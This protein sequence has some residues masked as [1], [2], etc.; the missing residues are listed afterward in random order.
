[1]TAPDPHERLDE[2]AAG[3]ALHALEP[4]D[5]QGFRV[6]LATCARCQ[7][8]VA[9]HTE[10]LSHLAYAA[11]PAEL[12]PSLLE[13]IRREVRGDAP[14]QPPEP[15]SLDRARHRR[16]PGLTAGRSWIAAAAAVALVLSLGVWNLALQR[17]KSRGDVR[18]ER[19]AA[20]IATLEQGAKQV[21]RLDDSDGRPVAVAL[22]RA[23][24][25]VS[26]VVDGL[27][28]NDRR[29]STYVLWQKGAYGV[30]A[31]GA[32]DV[33]TD[34]VDV[35]AGLRLAPDVAGLDGFAVTREPGRQAPTAPGSQPVAT[36]GLTA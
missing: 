14:A 35:V 18:N 1:V 20:A 26:L 29:A 3:Y 22:V 8:A 17:D 5:E 28:P 27:A 30:R 12:P 7:Q 36:G 13:G 15:V 32:F 10:T 9:E 2:L 6:H 31:V 24:D 19:L 34:D 4:G 16:R 25:S 21:V 23:D 33:R 11:A